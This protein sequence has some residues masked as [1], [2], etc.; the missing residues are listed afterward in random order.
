MTTTV[1]CLKVDSLRKDGID[2]LEQWMNIPN[3]VYTGRHGRVFIGKKSEGNIKVFTYPG[4]KWA[5]PYTLKEYPNIKKNL[6]M[7]VKHL[8]DSGLIYQIEEL[9]GKNLG[10]YCQRHRASD[11]S[12]TCHAQVLADLVEKCNHLIST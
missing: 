9:R 8:F 4:S 6:F 11:G 5:N 7:Y 12:P 1:T 3:N 2:N 10:C